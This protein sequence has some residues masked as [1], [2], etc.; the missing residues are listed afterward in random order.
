MHARAVETLGLL[1]S[2]QLV[3][4]TL[5]P[6]ERACISRS[7]DCVSSRLSVMRLTQNIARTTLVIVAAMSTL[8]CASFSQRGPV[9]ESVERCRQLSREGIDASQRGDTLR[10]NKL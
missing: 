4:A 3:P 2:V 10:T 8:G 1:L 9:P 7:L 6:P 5:S